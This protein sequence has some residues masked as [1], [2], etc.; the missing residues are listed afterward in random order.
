MTSRNKIKFEGPVQGGDV[1]NIE[2]LVGGRLSVG[3]V[4]F[5]GY[6]TGTEHAIAAGGGIGWMFT[7]EV[8]GVIGPSSLMLGEGGDS[9][10]LTFKLHEVGSAIEPNGELNGSVTNALP[11]MTSNSAPSPNVV[12][13]VDH[14]GDAVAGVANGYKAFDHSTAT[15]L[16]LY[17]R[18]ALDASAAVDKGGGLVGL[19]FTTYAGHLMIGSTVTIAGTI[20]YNGQHVVHANT[21][22]NELV[23]TETYV[24]EANLLGGYCSY[25]PSSSYPLY[26]TLDLGSGNNLTPNR[27]FVTERYTSYYL[28]DFTLVGS[29]LDNPDP[30]DDGDWATLV[31][32]SGVSAPTIE[33]QTTYYDF[34]N[35]LQYRHFRL[36][37]TNVKDLTGYAYI[38]QLGLIA[39]ESK[40]A[41]GTVI[42]TYD[43]PE[44]ITEDGWNDIPLPDEILQRGKTYFLTCNLS[45][46]GSMSAIKNRNQ[47]GPGNS[48]DDNVYC[49]EIDA[50][51][52]VTQALVDGLP[53]EFV[54]IMGSS[55][56]GATALLRYGRYTGKAFP[57]LND[58]PEEGITYD[59]SDLTADEEHW[60]YIYNSGASLALDVNT[61][62]PT[63][64]TD[65]NLVK[66]EVGETDRRLVGWIAPDQVDEEDCGVENRMCNRRL[67]NLFNRIE[68]PLGKPCP[69]SSNTTHLATVDGN[70]HDM[71]NS[72]GD[73]SFVALILPHDRIQIQLSIM[74]T[75]NAAALLN[76]TVKDDLPYDAR[77]SAYAYANYG[78]ITAL[79][80]YLGSLL[81]LVTF[82]PIYNQ[83]S[84]STKTF[85][86]YYSNPLGMLFGGSVEV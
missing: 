26:I 38:C 67:R 9:G 54:F 61:T 81:E 84:G 75:I 78:Q 80:D 12:S 18:H 56:N 74:S 73:L 85:F 13:V 53:A 44:T 8:D 64:D 37:V 22:A 11:V 21:T 14:N 59:V 71:G 77:Q 15:N 66:N 49:V 83:P 24:A 60:A 7:P 25:G 55:A 20:N 68:K 62:M 40:P 28:I 30:T 76:F 19:P 3:P 23:I 10:T 47:P 46:G 70:W 33:Y 17:H 5:T 48:L 36:K 34:T 57:G 31:S 69:Y 72:S 39:A 50:S 32:A 86:L 82:S 65:G 42:K 6:G 41:P 29:N 45:A 79:F 2:R 58:I 27:L 43:S 51:G 35:A 63:L 16:A 4:H 52:N 1:T